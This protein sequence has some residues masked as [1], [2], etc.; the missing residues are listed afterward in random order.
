MTQSL[1]KLNTVQEKLKGSE[2]VMVVI[3]LKC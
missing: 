2:N 3:Q 1:G